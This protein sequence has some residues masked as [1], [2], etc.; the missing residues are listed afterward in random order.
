M[1]ILPSTA[2]STDIIRGE[3]KAITMAQM[4]GVSQHE[5]TVSVSHLGK[6]KRSVSPELEKIRDSAQ[7]P[8]QDVL[9]LLRKYVPYDLHDARH[10]A[11]NKPIDTKVHLQ[12]LN[13]LYLQSIWT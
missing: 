5:D 12:F 11:N 2:T 7:Q 6:R 10:S 9:Q 8:G 13:S 1:L 4:N 3:P